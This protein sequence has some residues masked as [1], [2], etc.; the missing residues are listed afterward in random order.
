MGFL[1]LF[2]IT[3][4]PLRAF[5]ALRC[6]SRIWRK[7]GAGKFALFIVFA[8]GIAAISLS[9]PH[10]ARVFRCLIGMHCGANR[11]SGWFSLAYIGF[12]YL[13]FEAVSNIVLAVARKVVRVAT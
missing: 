7:S 1:G 10:V 13:A 8:A 4:L 5:H 11:S 9:I 2:G 6:N 3:L 12:I